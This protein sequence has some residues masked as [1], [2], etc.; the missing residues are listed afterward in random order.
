M[1]SKGLSQ[2]DAKID[3]A[4]FLGSFCQQKGNALNISALG[5]HDVSQFDVHMQMI[6]HSRALPIVLL[7]DMFAL[8]SYNFAGMCVTGEMFYFASFATSYKF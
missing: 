2:L 7:I 1:I 5:M 8:L 4:I 3:A 6:T